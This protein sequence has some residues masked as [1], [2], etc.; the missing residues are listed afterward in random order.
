MINRPLL[1]LILGFCFTTIPSQAPAYISTDSSKSRPTIEAVRVTNP[2]V[3]DGILNETEWQHPGFSSFTQRDPNEGAEP[4]QKTEVWVAY[5]DAAIY[6]A[7]RLYDTHPDSIV[8][9]IGRRD[10]DLSTDAFYVG[11]DSYHD[12]RS[13]FYFLVSAGGSIKDGTMFNDSWDDASW[14]GVWDA[15]TTIDDK[16]WCVEIRIPYSQLRFSQQ[17]QYTWGINFIRQ[18]DRNKERDDF[19]MVPKKE[20][21]WVSRFADLAGLR[22]IHPPRRFEAVPYTATSGKFLQHDAADPF[23]NGHLFNQNIGTDFKLGIGNNLTLNA[24]VNPDFGQVEVDPAVVNLTQFETYFDEKRPFFIEGSNFFDFG[25]GG[26]NNNWGFNFGTPTFFYTRRIGRP[27]QLG[28]QESGYAD[29]P[30]RT[31]ILGAAKFTG[32]ISDGWS[33]GALQAFTAREYDRVDSSGVRFADVVEPFTYYG[34]VRSLRE[35][36]DGH[37]AIGILGTATMR[38]LNHNYLANNLNRNAYSLA[39]DG[40]TNIDTAQMWVLTGWLA[41]SRIEGTPTQMLNLQQAPAHYYQRPDVDYV[42]LDSTAT[43]LGGYG[44]RIALNKQ[45]GNT[46]LN[47]AF[48]FISPGL[49]LNDLGYMYRTDLFNGHIVLG[50]NWYQPDDIFRSKWFDL[51]TF[52]N[53]DYDG[54]KIGEGYFL[55]YSAQLMN[56]W[57]FSGN[58]SYNP[59]VF[60]LYN[61]R[62]GPAMKNTNGYFMNIYGMTDSHKP[63]MLNLGFSGGR[64]ESGGYQTTWDPGIV[65]Q[66]TSSLNFSFTPELN[67]DVTIA[68][69]VTNQT[70]PTATATYGA[71]YVFGK[72]DLREVSAS[73][74]MDWTFTPKLTLQLYLQPLISVGSYNQFKEL[75]QPGTYTFNRYGI[76]NGSSITYETNT[77]S[78]QVTPNNLGSPSFKFLNPDFNYKSLRGNMILRWEYLP[79]STIFFVWTQQRYNYDD[80]GDFSFS[81]DFNNLIRNPGDNVFIVKVTYWWN[82]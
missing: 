67:H 53:Y 15:A 10:A 60:D 68:Q 42:H 19:V 70:D 64:T 36:N 73:I 58:M 49:D 47:A 54:R 61:T 16:G 82:P 6:I 50:Y 11:I 55:F 78:F 1:S 80:A 52:R 27:P 3:V 81:R 25:S 71:R 72:L 45:K 77:D 46:Y 79:G 34:V 21:G 44:G 20:S 4:T 26:A 39:V 13:G 65:W 28:P 63:V 57:S 24:T 8:S 69:W 7:A 40:W 76:D 66:P 62:G 35:F 2:I 29:I 14:D 9:R 5:D 74:R 18:I 48:G 43:S 17:D 75:K 37:Q 56:Y 31:H 51:A 22:D 33:I 41:A 30:D 12:H 32:K 59:A 38:D 23:N